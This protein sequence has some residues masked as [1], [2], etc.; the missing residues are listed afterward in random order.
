MYVSAEIFEIRSLV[1]RGMR[2]F[3]IYTEMT[4]L[5]PIFFFW[6]PLKDTFISFIFCVSCGPISNNFCV[7]NQFLWI[8]RIIQHN[9][10]YKKKKDV[11]NKSRCTFI[12]E[13]HFYFSGDWFLNVTLEIMKIRQYEKLDN[14][15]ASLITLY[16]YNFFIHFKIKHVS[17]S[18]FPE[19]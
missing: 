7:N 3:C 2:N 13:C 14:G 12:I 5:S 18:N 6:L 8:F 4:R 17:S 15:N 11:W 19:I 16:S 10:I 1:G 9:Y